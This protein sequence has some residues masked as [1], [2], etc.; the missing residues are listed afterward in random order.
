MKAAFIPKAEAQ[1]DDITV[2]AV[3][4]KGAAIAVPAGAEFTLTNSANG[5]V[6]TAVKQSDGSYAWQ[7]NG[8]DTTTVAPLE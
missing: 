3:D 7:E 6:Y 2:T 8:V 4:H 5:L 1:A